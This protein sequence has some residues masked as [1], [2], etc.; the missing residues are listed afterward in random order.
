MNL[1]FFPFLILYPLKDSR[2]RYHHT[3]PPQFSEDVQPFPGT[4]TVQPA[5]VAKAADKGIP[6]READERRWSEMSLLL[7]TSAYMY[8]LNA[9]CLCLDR[10]Y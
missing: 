4:A 8:W 1:I 10:I 3:L 7:D 5:T 9:C 6:V 2:Y